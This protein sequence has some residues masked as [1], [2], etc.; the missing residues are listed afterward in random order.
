[1]AIVRWDP[2]REMMTLR[3]SMDR[4]FDDSMFRRLQAVPD[5]AEAHLSMD[6]YQSEDAIVIQAVLPGVEPDDVDIS[7][8]GETVTI[9]GEVKKEEEIKEENYLLKE[10]QYGSYSR[11]LQMPIQVQGDK[12]E[13]MFENGLL[14][15]TLPKAEAVKPKQIKVSPKAIVEG[16]KK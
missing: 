16:K 9:K 1:M 10:R 3:N 15:L 8:T 13:A 2:F 11:T 6:V 4:M 5:G 12:A 14:T 7:I